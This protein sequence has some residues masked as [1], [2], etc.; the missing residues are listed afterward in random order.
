[1]TLSIQTS[2]PPIHESSLLSTTFPPNRSHRCPSHTALFSTSLFLYPFPA[3]TPPSPSFIAKKTYP[4]KFEPTFFLFLSTFSLL[5]RR[6]P[7]LPLPLHLSCAAPS[8]SPPFLRRS[9]FLSTFPAPLPLPLHLPCAAPSRGLASPKNTVQR[10]HER[11]HS[12]PLSRAL[13]TFHESTGR[14]PR[15]YQKRN[16]N[17]T[18]QSFAS[19]TLPNLE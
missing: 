11:N 2:P 1:M 13:A 12:P 5:Q 6:R 15:K 9:L 7:P 4:R 3:L 17:R 16:Y 10:K 19:L 14:I 8:S 18:R